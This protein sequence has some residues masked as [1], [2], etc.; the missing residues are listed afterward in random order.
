MTYKE[1]LTQLRA[2]I[3]AKLTERKTQADAILAIATELRSGDGR[4]PTEEESAQVRA[5]E[6]K[7]D[8]IDADLVDLRAQEARYEREVAMEEQLEREAQQRGE[9]RQ[10]HTP[11]VRTEERSEVY[12]PDSAARGESFFRDLYSLKATGAQVHVLG[13]QERMARYEQQVQSQRAAATSSFAGLIPPQYL[14]DEAAAVAR[15][16]RPVA[17]SVQHLDLPDDGMQLVIPKGTTGTAAAVQASENTTVAEQDEVWQNLTIPVITI[18]GQ[19]PLSR[20]AL[21]RGAQGIDQLVFT[22][23]AAAY[24]V[25]VD[26]EVIG[27]TGSSGHALGI[28]NTAGIGQA[29]AFTAA[30]SPATFMSKIA[31]AINT[32][33]TTRFAAP[34]VIYMHPRRWAWLTAQ[35]D[36]ANRPLVVPNPGAMNA[37]G[38]YDGV[39]NPTAVTPAGTLLGLPV[40]TDANIPVSV[41]TGPEDVVIVARSQDLLLWEANDGNPTNLQ[42]EQTLGNQLTITLVAYGYAA[43][44]AARYPSAVAVVGG[45]AAAGNGLIAPTF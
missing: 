24:A 11:A 44:T 12:N 33:Q 29:L 32:V 36:G 42:F 26:A 40:I 1:L 2:S 41:G 25:S 37:F 18:A 27:G 34:N 8:G 20:Q 45:N 3:S 31:G 19:Q 28:L 30:V 39:N 10:D 15:A 13:A 16:G 7:V 43:F 5:A 35:V 14:I 21:E 9:Q 23:L 6:L 22:D 38:S 4:N 17:N